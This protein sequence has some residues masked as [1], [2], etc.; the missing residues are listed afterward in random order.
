MPLRLSDS[1]LDA[2]LAGLRLLQHEMSC[3]GWLPYK[4]REIY[5]EHGHGHGLATSEIDRLCERLNVAQP[6]YVPDDD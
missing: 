3:G 1:E 2:V 5:T 6:H 4:I